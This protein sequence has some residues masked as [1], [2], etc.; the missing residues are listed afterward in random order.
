MTS[1]HHPPSPI[2]L[3]L[4]GTVPYHQALALMRQWTRARHAARTGSGRPPAAGP[5]L[6][7]PAAPATDSASPRR[8]W[9]DPAEAAQRGDEIWLMQHPPVF[10]LGLNARTEHLHDT[11]DIP[12]VA[13]ERGGQVTY[14]GPGQIMAYLM[15]DLRSRRLGIR[16]LVERAEDALIHCL[17]QYGIAAIRQA[18]A[19]G[20]YVRQAQSAGRQ[21]APQPP[22][23]AASMPQPRAGRPPLAMPEPGVAKIA[24]IGLK[25]SHGLTYHGLALNGQMDLGPFLRINPCGFQN[26]PM[27]DVHQES[28]S[29]ADIDLE[30]LALA[31]GHALQAAIDG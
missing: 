19:P 30:A 22:A 13:T 15:I 6:Q 25:A 9:P 2:Q 10:T 16:H 20:I 11:G 26:L 5:A 3:R 29:Q 8:D 18:G 4:L 17:R 12:V 14:H 24:S 27:T 28:G 23:T 21:P 7:P 31:L 1:A